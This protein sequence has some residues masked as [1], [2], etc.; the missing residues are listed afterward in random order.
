MIMSRMITMIMSI[1]SITMIM[2]IMSILSR[3]HRLHHFLIQLLHSATAWATKHFIQH[4]RP[5]LLVADILRP[6]RLRVQLLPVILRAVLLEAPELLASLVDIGYKT[7]RLV[8]IGYLLLHRT[9][10]GDAS[11]CL[12]W[13]FRLF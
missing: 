6:L 10:L 13:L 3:L 7:P 2:S 12:F 4:P 8:D 11:I 5:F 1:M 9:K